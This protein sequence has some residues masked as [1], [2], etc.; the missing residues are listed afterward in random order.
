MSQQSPISDKIPWDAKK[1]LHPFR[2]DQQHHP[3]R[4]IPLCTP[5]RAAALPSQ[6]SCR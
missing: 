6:A 2:Q 5:F 3:I 1:Y 4:Q